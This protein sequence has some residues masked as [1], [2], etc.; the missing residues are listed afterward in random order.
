MRIIWHQPKTILKPFIRKMWIVEED[1][2]V[3]IEVNAFPVG[4]S[5]INVISGSKFK[6]S[7][8]HK[9]S[10]ETTS[11]LAGPTISSFVLNMRLVNRALT[12]QFQ[13]YA[14]SYIVGLPANEFY[15]EKLSLNDFNPILAASLE[16]AVSSE[17]TSLS[18]LEHCENI[19]LSLCKEFCLDTRVL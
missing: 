3:N 10:I 6:I 5:F 17:L 14:L 9:E 19:L 11:Y 1:N 8:S 13:P 12:V 16:E 2:G 18:V 15:D 7:S 4:Y